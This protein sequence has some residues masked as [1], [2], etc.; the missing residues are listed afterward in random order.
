MAPY[1]IKLLIAVRYDR[2]FFVAD[3]EV[4]YVMSQS[5]S[6]QIDLELVI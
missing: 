3:F 1:R 4:S 5:F 6:V 2:T